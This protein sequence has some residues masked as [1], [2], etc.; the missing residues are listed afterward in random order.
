MLRP[1]LGALLSLLASAAAAVDVDMSGFA[2]V[3]YAISD[4]PYRYQRFVDE[5]GTFARDS[6]L[7]FQLDARLSPT[8]GGTV[9]LR[10]APADDSDSG[11]EPS[12]AWAFLSWRPRDDLLLRAGKLRIPLML[13]TENL[14]VGVTYPYARL[15]SEVYATAPTSDIYGAMFSK[16][17]WQGQGEW[18]LD[19]YYG[20][21]DAQQRLYYRVAAGQPENH[22]L[23]DETRMK[24]GGLVLSLR[25][26]DDLYRL[27]VHRIETRRRHGDIYADFAFTPLPPPYQPGEGFYDI[28]RSPQTSHSISRML[29][30]GAAIALPA[31]FRLSA[32]YV[33][34]LNDRAVNGWDRW[35][36]YAALSRRIGAWTPYLSYA[37]MRSSSHVL[38]LYDDVVSN[39]VSLPHPAIDASQRAVADTLL[40]HEQAT[41]ALGTAYR[42]SAS[43]VLK[44]EWAHTRTD[45]VSSFIDA[46]AGDD[47]AD[48]RLNV[49]SLSCSF[50]F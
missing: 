36:A 27:G 37:R 3:G 49:F 33:R 43:M 11:W 7:G 28:S 42:L 48:Q 25:H 22:A 30:I 18:S 4:Q 39:R 5:H 16:T 12:L 31:D 24:G 10:V 34:L 41:V 14:D 50:T 26:E 19:G 46:P 15:P 47:S 9:Q 38:D 32:E 8:L 29:T 17:W 1:S 44:A 45:R 6:V 20:R 13:D 40:A 2:T 23:Y 35:A 21:I